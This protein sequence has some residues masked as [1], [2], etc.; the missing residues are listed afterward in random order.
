M[1]IFFVLRVNSVLEFKF[2]RKT[3]RVFFLNAEYKNYSDAKLCGYK[4]ILF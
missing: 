1:K 4:L 3:Q 2:S